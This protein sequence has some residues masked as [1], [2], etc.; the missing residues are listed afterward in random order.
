M[1]KYY[2]S[3]SLVLVILLQACNN[4][5][6][7]NTKNNPKKDDT[8]AAV[9]DTLSANKTERNELSDSQFLEKVES[10]VNK[11]KNKF[12]GSYEQ[13]DVKSGDYDGDKYNDFLAS[14]K[15]HEDGTDYF[16]SYYFYQS[17]TNDQLIPL[18]IPTVGTDKQFSVRKIEKDK[19]FVT[20]YIGDAIMGEKNFN[21][22][23]QIEND[24]VK[25]K[26]ADISRADKLMNELMI[27]YSNSQMDQE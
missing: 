21:S 22:T 9:T 15:F 3:I 16:K 24:K 20:F 5:N 25:F 10:Y 14:V 19:I 4:D 23:I 13:T 27:E 18:K 1:N 6:K 8:K 11:N 7:D 26:E 12:I 17:S 2:F